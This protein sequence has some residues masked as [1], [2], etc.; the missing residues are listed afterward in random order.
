MPEKS[1]VEHMALSAKLTG[2]KHHPYNQMRHGVNVAEN[3]ARQTRKGI[4]YGLVLEWFVAEKAGKAEG[5]AFLNNVRDVEGVQ[6]TRAVY[7]FMNQPRLGDA[8]T[9]Q[10]KILSGL[11]LKHAKDKEDE[12]KIKD[13]VTSHA[14]D[15]NELVKWISATRGRRYYL[16]HTRDH[17]IGLTGSWGGPYKLFDPNGGIVEC[18]TAS[19]MGKFITDYFVNS[20]MKQKYKS[21]YGMVNFTVEKLKAA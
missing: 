5:S 14:G 20:P 17:C 8:P 9:V 6:F 7:L 16:M 12:R 11:S 4:C 10:D 1:V 21:H 3:L 15:V 18:R 2:L 13:I 19:S